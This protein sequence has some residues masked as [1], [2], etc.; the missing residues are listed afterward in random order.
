MDEFDSIMN[1]LKKSREAITRYEPVHGELV[2][3]LHDI[4]SLQLE[5]KAAHDETKAVREKLEEA[6]ESMAS[7]RSSF[8][9]AQTELERLRKERET[10]DKR[11]AAACD[12][13]EKLESDLRLA[14]STLCSINEM[15]ES[16]LPLQK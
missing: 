14:R 12:D 13:I 1:L 3:A 16:C 15:I 10:N 11:Y 9:A 5:L 6:Q 7:W 2:K 4:D 8:F